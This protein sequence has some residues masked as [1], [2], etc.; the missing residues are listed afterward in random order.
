MITKLTDI[1]T[2]RK[3]TLNKYHELMINLYTQYLLSCE[4]SAHLVRRLSTARAKGI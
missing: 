1:K 3:S 4:G 2:K